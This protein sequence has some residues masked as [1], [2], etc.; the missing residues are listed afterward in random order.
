[1]IDVV[2]AIPSFRRPKGLERLLMALEKIE[3]DA[4]ISVLV[5]DNDAEKREASAVCE[6]LRK[7]EYRWPLDCI[8]AEERGIAQTRNAL[9]DH[10]LT[11]S[12]A[13][14][15][16]MLDDDEWPAPQWLDAFLKV[17]RTTGAD[18]LHGA[19]LREFQSEPSHW[20]TACHGI[21][22]MRNKT[23]IVPM[24]GGTSNVLLRRSC[25]EGLAKPC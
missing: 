7:Q 2:V 6:R 18:A 12:S 23:G 3:T 8:I 11:H 22:P 19:V 5:A 4:G 24:I 13:A 1:M 14:F 9:V 16:A 15:V 21:A 25:F 20:A 10:I 17:Q